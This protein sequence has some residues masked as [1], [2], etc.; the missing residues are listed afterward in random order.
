MT[1][2]TAAGTEFCPEI[3]R[4]FGIKLNYFVV[5]QCV[6]MIARNISANRM[7]L[8]NVIDVMMDTG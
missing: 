2:S 8:G 5:F 1:W 3:N 6:L 4:N 7:A